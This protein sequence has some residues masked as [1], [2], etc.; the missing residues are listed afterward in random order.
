MGTPDGTRRPRRPLVPD[1]F[2]VK[3]GFRQITRP[4]L[5]ADP[6]M[7]AE[8][9]DKGRNEPGEPA[10]RDPVPHKLTIRPNYG[11]NAIEFEMTDQD[12]RGFVITI[13]DQDMPEILLES[14]RAWAR[15]GGSSDT[16]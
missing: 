7:T 5:W 4:R 10:L 11:L 3:V 8:D 6:A 15:L 13:Y 1:R 14:L 9:D 12:G 2:A 16:P